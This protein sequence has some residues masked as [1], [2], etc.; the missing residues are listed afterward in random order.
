MKLRKVMSLAAVAVLGALMAGQTVMA[1]T[2]SEITPDQE[3][4]QEIVLEKEEEVVPTYTVDVPAT[5]ILSKD[6]QNLSFSM[7]LE[8][9]ENFIPDGKKVS[10]VIESAGYPTD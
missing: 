10:V 5:V 9:H 4:Q 3:V 2:V 8:N 6:A 1:A 7:N